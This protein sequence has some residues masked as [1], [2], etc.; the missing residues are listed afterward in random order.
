ML[1]LICYNC[2]DNSETSTQDNS[3]EGSHL[4]I[5]AIKK[6]IPDGLKS[7]KK[8]KYI[9]ESGTIKEVQVRYTEEIT[10]RELESE[11]YKS[12]ELEI[13]LYDEMD[14][15][16]QIVLI[17]STNYDADYSVVVGLTI[18]YMPANPT[19]TILSSI[20]FDEGGEPIVNT[21]DDFRSSISLNNKTFKDCFVI[22]GTNPDSYSEIY[23]NS[24]VGVVA[25][26]DKAN[27][28]FVFEEFIN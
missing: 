2:K 12:D 26:R 4:D 17:G 27:E 18:L 3:I 13:T 15:K 28:L 1:G 20:R 5:D 25:F 14:E 16:F 8:C 22:T 21:Y 9:N 6:F 11:S 7:E 24:E 10:E 23:I 19:G